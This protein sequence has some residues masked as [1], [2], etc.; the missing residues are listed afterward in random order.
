MPLGV[1]TA[2]GPGTK[3]ILEKL[4]PFVEKLV[5][6]Y[7]QKQQTAWENQLISAVFAD[8]DKTA[9][10]NE[11]EDT[12]SKLNS[13]PPYLDIEGAT[14]TANDVMGMLKTQE[15]MTGGL[16]A[17]TTPTTTTAIEGQPQQPEL[18]PDKK[19]WGEVF[20]IFS[21]I[22]LG[23]NDWANTKALVKQRLE[24]GRA[25]GAL[26]SQLMS[27]IMG[28]QQPDQREVIGKNIDLTNKYMEGMYPESEKPS[29]N[30]EWFREEPE[31]YKEFANIGKETE[32]K[33]D[34][35]ALNIFMKDNGL[36]IKSV[37]VNEKGERNI[38]LE[39]IGDTELGLEEMLEVIKE[40]NSKGVKA[41]YSKN[42][43]SVSIPE[44]KT[45]ST[46][47]KL[48]QEQNPNGTYAEWMKASKTTPED[49]PKTPAYGT[50]TNIGEDLQSKVENI[51]DFVQELETLKT[52]KIDTSTFE[53]TEYFAKIMKKKYD[54]AISVIQYC[55]QGMQTGEDVDE[56]GLNYRDT[57]KKW[58][59]KAM[60]YDQEYFNVTGK[61]LLTTGE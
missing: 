53:T 52:L 58:W 29:S 61:K 20:K 31:K 7:K 51:D 46:P 5:G 26:G 18:I 17:P 11:S 50:Y 32:G 3:S 60:Q 24:S 15:I 27:M 40:L 33:L 6:V 21:D 34:I 59:K 42:G 2:S 8:I 16:T 39:P 9:K 36:Q 49:T 54:E 38:S 44:P 23:Q 43:L 14:K 10:G 25:I 47:F 45:T 37:T 13:P 56:D 12:I 28:Q 57:Y 1:V 55:T 19:E 4:N 41:S 35:D 30:Y 48:W 22:E